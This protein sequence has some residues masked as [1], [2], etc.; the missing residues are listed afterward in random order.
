MIELRNDKIARLEAELA[1]LRTML[2]GA[3]AVLADRFDTQCWNGENVGY[4]WN[5]E[6]L[7]NDLNAALFAIGQGVEKEGNDAR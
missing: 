4:V 3:K 6:R 5:C 1:R 2:A 7:G